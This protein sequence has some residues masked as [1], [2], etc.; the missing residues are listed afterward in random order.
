MKVAVEAMKASGE[1]AR[2]RGGW[3]KKGMKSS[4]VSPS[5]AATWA[6]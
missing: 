5:A 6:A 4:P 1:V 3:T 2:P